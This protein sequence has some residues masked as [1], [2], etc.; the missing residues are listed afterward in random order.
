M[1]AKVLEECSCPRL[2]STDYKKIQRTSLHES[3]SSHLRRYDE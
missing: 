1:M 2:V 3:R